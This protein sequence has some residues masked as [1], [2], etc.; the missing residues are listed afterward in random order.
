MRKDTKTNNQL[1]EILLLDIYLAVVYEK[2]DI[3]SNR[4][5]LS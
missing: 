4:F 3:S 2:H 1:Q 5:L